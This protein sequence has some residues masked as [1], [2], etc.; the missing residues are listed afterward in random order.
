MK[1]GSKFALA[2]LALSLVP[3][4]LKPG[5]DGE[6]S[7]KSLLLG[8]SSRKNGEGKRDVTI[9]L[10]NLP[11][12]LQK[13]KPAKLP[14]HSRTRRP[15]PPKRQTRPMARKDPGCKQFHRLQGSGPGPLPLHRTRLKGDF[16]MKYVCN[17]CG[18]VYDEDEAGVKWEDLPE[19]FAC[20]LCGVGKE[21][22]SPEE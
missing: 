12:F 19:D 1:K 7:F 20:E 6:F 10:F 3:F 5:K 21:D 22:F 15:P 4:E 2:A 8:V 9:S 18:W 14:V 16:I 17:V 11:E 13:R